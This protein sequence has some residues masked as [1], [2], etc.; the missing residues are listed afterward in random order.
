M[1]SVFA[2]YLQVALENSSGAMKV[3]VVEFG[4]DKPFEGI[5]MPNVVSMLESEPLTSVS[6]QVK[7]YDEHSL[8]NSFMILVGRY[9]NNNP[10]TSFGSVFGPNG[11]KNDKQI[12]RKWSD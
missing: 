6:I 3:K 2:S 8:N 11:S 5:F 10:N 7:I 9:I 4:G 1:G 12:I